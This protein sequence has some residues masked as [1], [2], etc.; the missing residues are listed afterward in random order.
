[1]RDAEKLLPSILGPLRPTR[2]PVALSRFGLLGLPSAKLLARRFDE[3][4]ARALIAG[5]AAHSM[6]RL[7]QPADRRRSRWC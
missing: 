2:H 1:M 7:D 3:P 6:L 5:N 4:R